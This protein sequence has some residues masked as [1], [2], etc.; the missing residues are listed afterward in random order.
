VSKL[1]LGA[2]ARDLGGNSAATAAVTLAVAP[3]PLTQVIGVVVD[4]SGLPASN[5]VVTTL[6]GRSGASDDLGRFQIVG[7]P[8]VLGPVIVQAQYTPAGGVT[9]K[10]SSTVTAPIVAGITDIGRISLSEVYFETDYGDYWTNADDDFIAQPLSFDFPF[11]GLSQST[12]YVGTNGYITFDAGDDNYIEEIG[13]LT[14]LP[15]ISA[16]FDD[17]AGEEGSGGIYINNKMAERLVV[18]HDRVGHFGS[19]GANT[20]QLQ[21]FKDGRIVFAYQGITALTTGTIV[22]LS[23]GDLPPVRSVDFSQSSNIEIAP[24]SAVYEYFTPVNPFDLDHAFVIFTP[25]GGGYQVRT[26]LSTPPPAVS[27]LTGGPPAQP[28]FAAPA[29]RS[30]ALTQHTA[31]AAPFGADAKTAALAADTTANAEV[32]VTSSTDRQYLGMTNTDSQGRFTLAGVPPGG[33]NVLIRRNGRLCARA[34]SVFAGGALNQ[35]QL[36]NIEL[37]PA[38]I[39]PKEGVPKR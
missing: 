38:E 18:T 24:G 25:I 30:A 9:Q 7:V 19:G 39:P 3:D 32:L 37:I 33:I 21:L 12:A 1:T 14:G 16:F 5:A 13:A 27:T 6:G 8:T 11:Y 23:P 15:R 35:A 29:L 34:A 17:L 36:L 4:E 20:I 26:I 31:R 2:T 28:P 22:G 10:G